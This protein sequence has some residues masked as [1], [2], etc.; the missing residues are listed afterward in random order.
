MSRGLIL[1]TGSNISI[2]QPGISKSN[3]QVT[4]MEPYRVTGDTLDIKGQQTVTFRMNGRRFT[5]PFLVCSLPTT[6]AGLLGTDFLSRL[7][8][9]LDFDRSKMSIS[10]INNAPRGCNA[11]QIGHVALTAFS[12]ESQNTEP[13]PRGTE[14]VNE[15][16]LASPN[17]RQ[18]PR[19]IKRGSLEL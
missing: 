6:A 9:K 12:E 16:L 5:H 3:V 13:K 14:R 4:T 7:G 8:A 11:P 17:L 1:D 2:M 15:Q 19:K 18:P 10:D